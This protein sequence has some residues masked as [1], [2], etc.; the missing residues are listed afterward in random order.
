ML[1]G[2]TAGLLF[3][4]ASRGFGG[5]GVELV[6]VQGRLVGGYGDEESGGAN[7]G[8][9]VVRGVATNNEGETLAH[10]EECLGQV[11]GGGGE[12]EGKHPLVKRRKDGE[13]RDG[14]SGGETTGRGDEGD[15][16]KRETGSIGRIGRRKKNRKEEWE[17]KE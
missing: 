16:S 8:T 17:G 5:L 3:P 6:V 15:Y 10:L 11:E 12:R 4:P 7:A 14:G 9:E 2:S 1:F 13:E